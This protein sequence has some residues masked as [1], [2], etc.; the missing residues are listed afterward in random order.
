MAKTISPVNVWV[1]GQNKEAK[2]LDSYGT[3]VTFGKSAQFYWA[4]YEETADGKQG[5]QVAQGNIPLEGAD[6]QL[7]NDDTYAWDYVANKL[8][9]TITGDFVPPIQQDENI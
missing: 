9:L 2:I 8:S 6:Y 4:I 3:R 5:E 1:N 7:W